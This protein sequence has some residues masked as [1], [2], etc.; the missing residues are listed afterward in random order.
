MGPS[1]LGFAYVSVQRGIARDSGN[2]AW[3][4]R[5]GAG[6]LREIGWGLRPQLTLEAGRQVN[7]APLALFGKIRKDWRLQAS[8]SIYKRDWNF[9]GF[10]PSLR[11]SW[12]RSYSTITLYDQQRLRDLVRVGKR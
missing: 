6:V 11:L 2:S 10:A 1:T 8:A 12:S 4:G 3:S 5:I 9:A 7:D